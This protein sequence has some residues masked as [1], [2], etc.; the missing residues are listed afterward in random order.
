MLV[1]EGAQGLLVGLVLPGLGFLRFLDQLELFKKD[2]ADLLGRSQVEFRSRG[3]IDLLLQC[4]DSFLENHPDLGENFGVDPDALLFHADDGGNKG[5]FDLEEDPFLLG[6][7]ELIPQD[8]GELP[9]DVGILRRVISHRLQVGT[10]SPAHLCL[11]EET[12]LAG[13]LFLFPENRFIGNRRIGQIPLREVIHPMPLLRFDHG[14][15]QHR[16]EERARRS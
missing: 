11:V 8:P 10:G 9:G 5:T 13:G 6:F 12:H 3:V 4:L 7:L 14:M 1:G 2:L 15:G 16:V